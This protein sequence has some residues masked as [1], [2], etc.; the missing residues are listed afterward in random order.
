M[1]EKGG[2]S[3]LFRGNKGGH[4][5]LFARK[6]AIPP[7]THTCAATF[8]DRPTA[9]RAGRPRFA[10][11]QRETRPKLA[12]GSTAGVRERGQVQEK[13][14]AIAQVTAHHEVIDTHQDHRP[15]RVNDGPFVVR[16]E[17]TAGEAAAECKLANAVGECAGDR[18]DILNQS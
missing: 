7:F 5:T 8:S 1:P 16:E 14:G 6:S 4:N 12:L 13:N 10:D 3:A 15:L 17:R 11:G 9:A 2:H 18:A